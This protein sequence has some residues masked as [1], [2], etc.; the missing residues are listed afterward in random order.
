MSTINQRSLM[1]ARRIV[2]KL[3][4]SGA[5]SG[6]AALGPA[7]LSSP[8]PFASALAQIVPSR[9]RAAWTTPACRKRQASRAC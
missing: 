9:V 7:P 3:V 4:V 5:M 2:Q 8:V 1:M 6:S